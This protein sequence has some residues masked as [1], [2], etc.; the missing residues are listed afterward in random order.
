M[1]ATDSTDKSSN[2]VR[3]SDF[4]D[5]DHLELGKIGATKAGGVNRQALTA[6]DS[7]AR[8]L[9]I[10]WAGACVLADVIETRANLQI[11]ETDS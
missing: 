4:V 2:P 9:V 8:R 6:L 3:L 10:E 1:P 7:Q 5:R 11:S